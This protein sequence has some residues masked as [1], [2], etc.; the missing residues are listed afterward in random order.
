[1]RPRTAAPHARAVRDREPARLGLGGG[2]PAAHPA[3]RASARRPHRAARHRLRRGRRPCAPPDPR[4]CRRGDPRR[5]GDRPRRALPRRRAGAGTGA[6]GGGRAGA[7]A[8]SHRGIRRPHA[9]AGVQRRPRRRGALVRRRGLEPRAAP[10]RRGA[11]HGAARR[12]AGALAW[13]RAALRHRALAD[14]LRGVRRGDH[15]ARTGSFL[16]TD[17]LRSVRRSFTPAEL[18]ARVPAGWRVERPAPF[19]LL[20]T[21]R[22]SS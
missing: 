18:A 17:G 2:V 16:R 8:G 15:P 14:G 12:F 7:R 19:R 9:A 20:A 13:A 11:A 21:W 22:A 3:P 1:M 4:A 10:P 6:S 5:R